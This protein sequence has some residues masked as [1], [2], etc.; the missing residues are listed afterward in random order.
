MTD[1]QYIN[2]KPYQVPVFAE[3]EESRCNKDLDVLIGEVIVAQRTSD[4]HIV[5]VLNLKETDDTALN[6]RVN[7][8]YDLWHDSAHIVY[9]ENT[10]SN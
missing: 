4:R 8:I 2:I 1:T 6:D 3:Q 7:N 5:F 10:P 9:L